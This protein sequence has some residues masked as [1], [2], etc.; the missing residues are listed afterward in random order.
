MLLQIRHITTYH[1]DKAVYCE[2]LTIRLRPRDDWFHRLEN[3]RLR[4]QPE[5]AGITQY[6]DLHGNDVTR[7]WFKGFTAKLTVTTECVVET[8]LHNPFSFLLAPEAVNLPLRHCEKFN[9]LWNYYA[10]PSTDSDS[11]RQLASETLLESGGETL[12]FLTQLTGRIY[13]ECETVVR[14]EGAAFDPETTWRERRGACRD[15]AILFNEVCRLAG[16]PAR[17]VSGYG[18][19]DQR[20]E[21][22]LHAWSEVY[23]PGAGWRGFDPT[24]GLAVSDRH[25]AVATSRDPADAAPTSGTYRGNGVDSRLETQVILQRLDET[26]QTQSMR[27]SSDAVS[28]KVPIALVGK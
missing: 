17:F 5:P 19:S 23:L 24:I 3:F 14:P 20:E 6:T 11:L 16:L 21:R 1:Y 4:V 26:S 10:E 2:P 12:T 28:E 8:L 18:Y 7:C 13:R 9:P 25:V 22:H 27:Q 15:Q